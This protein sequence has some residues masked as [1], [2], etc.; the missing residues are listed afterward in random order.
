MCSKFFVDAFATT[1]QPRDLIQ[2]DWCLRD[3]DGC[4]VLLSIPVNGYGHV[5]T[6]TSGF[7]GILPDIEM[8]DTQVL[9]Q[10]A[11]AYIHGRSNITHILGRLTG[12]K[13]DGKSIWKIH[14]DFFFENPFF[15]N[16]F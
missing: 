5:G 9:Q 3:C 2:T 14:M 13:L 4:Y 10:R 16:L 7:V 8:N 12:V 6:L 1:F 15:L 11:K